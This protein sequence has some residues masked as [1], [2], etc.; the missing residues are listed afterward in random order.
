MCFDELEA[1]INDLPEKK[2]ALITVLH[3]AQE[4]FGYLPKEVQE[5]IAEKLNLPVSKVYGV[6]RFYS[7]FTMIPRGENHLSICMG[8]ACY[9]NGA[10]DL[11]E[12]LKK[13]LGIGVGEVSSDGKFSIHTLRCIGAC[14]LAPVLSIN[15]DV[16]GKVKAADIKGILSNY[17]ESSHESVPKNTEGEE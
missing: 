8:T 10:E 4:I 5:F 6:V 11:L 16:Y 2:G 7:Y 9:V 1:F 15:G 12:V 14:S 13:E 3:K 17:I